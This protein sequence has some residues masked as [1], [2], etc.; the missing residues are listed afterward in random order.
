[1]AAAGDK[2]SAAKFQLE[3]AVREDMKKTVAAIIKA[4]G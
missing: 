4:G 1:V 2:L 3:T